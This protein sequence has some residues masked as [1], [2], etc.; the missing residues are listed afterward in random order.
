[1][2]KADMSLEELMAIEPDNIK[3]KQH[4]ALK[5]FVVNRLKEVTEIIEN[6]EYDKVNPYLNHSPAGDGY[7]TDKDF[8]DFSMSEKQR[9]DNYGTDISEVID[10][11]KELKIDN[12]ALYFMDRR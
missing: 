4:D 1:M 8:I 9:Q 12:D 11:L 3:Q 10:K 6:E 2:I 7:G 5:G